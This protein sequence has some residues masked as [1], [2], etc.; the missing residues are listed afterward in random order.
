MA[1]WHHN[2]CSLPRERSKVILASSVY[3]SNL[4]PG[5]PILC[6]WHLSNTFSSH[7]SYKNDLTSIVSQSVYPCFLFCPLSNL[8]YNLATGVISK[9]L[10]RFLYRI[11]EQTFQWIPMSSRLSP[12]SSWH[13]RSSSV[14]FLR[15]A[16]PASCI[17]IQHHTLCVL[18]ILV[19][20]SQ[21]AVSYH[22]AFVWAIL[23]G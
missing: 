1:Q 3:Q 16:P 2:L 15:S 11:P 20:H 13:Q 12:S 17:A 23:S 14:I 21:Q 19:L 9:K 6:P 8:F 18:A 7:S 4:P 5:S 10:K 22:C